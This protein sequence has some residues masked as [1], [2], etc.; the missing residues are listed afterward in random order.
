MAKKVVIPTLV[1]VDM[2]PFF[3]I[4]VDWR[5]VQAVKSLVDR[6]I[7]VKAAIVLLELGPNLFDNPKLRTHPYI[8][9][10]LFGPPPYE[11]YSVVTKFTEDGSQEVIQECRAKGFGMDYLMVCGVKT[12]VCVKQTV[13][14]LSVK[15]PD[16]RIEVVKDACNSD[17]RFDWGNMPDAG[18]ITLV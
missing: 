5:T 4:S 3:S 14:G 15:L 12:H 1:V 11:S 16:S 6:M 9:R 10:P 18:N 17:C 2:Q 7:E 8:M 13:F